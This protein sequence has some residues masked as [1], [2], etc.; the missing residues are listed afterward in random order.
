MHGV[1]TL[2]QLV[3]QELQRKAGFMPINGAAMYQKA[4]RLVDGYNRLILI[5]D[6][7]G[8]LCRSNLQASSSCDFAAFPAVARVE[9]FLKHLWGAATS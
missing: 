4:R 3:A 5:N 8:S 7:E 6:V 9:I 2:S 1:Y